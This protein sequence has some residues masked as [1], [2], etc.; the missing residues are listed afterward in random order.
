MSFLTHVFNHG[1]PKPANKTIIFFRLSWTIGND[2]AHK[3][4]HTARIFKRIEQVF[5]EISMGLYFDTPKNLTSA[6]WQ[7]WWYCTGRWPVQLWKA[8]ANLNV[9]FAFIDEIVLPA[10]E[11][12]LNQQT[13]Y[14][15]FRCKLSSVW[16]RNLKMV[17]ALAKEIYWEV[18]TIQ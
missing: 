9:E 8:T 1:Q 13:T 14:E 5:L 15:S 11:K 12:I 17:G 6:K 7:L 2:S 16:F 3:G 4:D 18:Q 10:T